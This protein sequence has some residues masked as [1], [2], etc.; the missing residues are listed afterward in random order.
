MDT[1][2]SAEIALQGFVL[3]LAVSERKAE[4]GDED[5]LELTALL[6]DYAKRPDST[7]A[8]RLVASKELDRICAM[9][10]SKN[11]LDQP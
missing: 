11:R 3:A 1:N 6:A 10:L 8:G 5:V 9:Y 7:I 4:I 2:V